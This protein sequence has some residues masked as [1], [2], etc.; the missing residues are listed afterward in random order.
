MAQTKLGYHGYAITQ[1]TE[2]CGPGYP[3]GSWVA[4]TPGDYAPEFSAPTL[5]QLQAEID[6][7]QPQPNPWELPWINH[8]R[9]L[10]AA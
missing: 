7:D 10:Q 1:L 8:Q 2:D 5:E 9:T 4:Y 6:G 3:P